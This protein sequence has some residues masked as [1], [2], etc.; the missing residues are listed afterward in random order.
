MA[1]QTAEQTT[2]K[3][4]ID[5]PNDEVAQKPRRRFIIIGVVAI[6]V[7]VGLL[8]WWHSTYYED[9]DDAQVNGHLI[10]ISARVAG[11]IL[12]VN[13]DENQ[14]VDA[15]TVIAELDPSDFQ[16]AVQQD[17]ANL[18]SAEAS[19]EAA[20]VTV[21]VTHIN[22]GSTLTSAGA[23]VSSA[24]S[25]VV[26]SEHQLQAAQAA[27]QQAEAN[28]TKAQLDLQRYK[29]L[30]EKDVISKQQFDAAVASADGDKAALEQ[31]KA[32]LEAANSAVRVAKDKVASAQASYKNAET[33]PQQVAI[34]KAKADQAA[35]MVEQSKA[36]LAQAKLNLSYTQIVAPTAGIVTK[37]S[38][39]VGQNVSVGQNM[40]TLVSL[41][42]IWITANFKE[43]QL[44]H[45]RQGQHVTISV[46]AYGGRKYDGKITQIG[47]ATGSVL[48]LFPPE[49]ATGNY[50][51]VVQRIPV[52]I[53]LTDRNENSDHLLRPGMSVEPKVKVK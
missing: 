31:S 16:T 12:K 10:Q 27:V 46:D 45:M 5:Q 1:E 25:Q 40:A 3:N 33:G 17:E 47:G 14:Y 8:W 15:G 44:E 7:V 21:P 30:V 11:H 50:V 43:T 42:D 4:R 6:L 9:T 41:D 29:P 39:E 48:S 22:T 35:A 51:K 49:N 26:Q 53:D 23:D 36:A 28:N 32:Q 18:E 19:Y 20:K 52:R 2:E 24:S 34:Q 13:V 38:V 37:K